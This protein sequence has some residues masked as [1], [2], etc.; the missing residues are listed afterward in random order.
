[1]AVAKKLT[2]KC[3][4][5]KNYCTKHGDPCGDANCKVFKSCCPPNC[6]FCVKKECIEG[7]R[8][9]CYFCECDCQKDDEVKKGNKLCKNSTAC[10][11]CAEKCKDVKDK[12][13]LCFLCNCGDHCDGVN[14]QCC[15][16]CNPYSRCPGPDNCDQ[17]EDKHDEKEC[18]KGMCARSPG[19][20]GVCVCKDKVKSASAECSECKCSCNGDCP[21]TKC[22][23][24]KHG[25]KHNCDCTT[26]KY[27]VKCVCEC[28]CNCSSYGQ[29]YCSEHI[30][31]SECSGKGCSTVIYYAGRCRFKCTN[32]GKLCSQDEFR[33]RCYIGVPILLIAVAIIVAWR[34]YP[35]KF[36]KVYYKLSAATTNSF[37]S[38]GASTNLA[39]GRIHEEMD[40]DEYSAF[41]FKGL[42]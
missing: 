16:W 2:N 10:K 19:T 29:H 5:D 38:S 9:K 31:I 36:R 41:P 30:D 12:R 33:R 4:C 23:K 37:K 42:M 11:L 6:Q 14:C 3:G 40:T 28:T 24:A 39:G 20:C 8:C 27:A 7:E 25:P 1:M 22:F 15:K 35:E 13:C 34:K 17:K 26:D 32:C 18:N 21:R